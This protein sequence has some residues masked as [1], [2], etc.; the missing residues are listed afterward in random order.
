MATTTL[1]TEPR[2]APSVRSVFDRL[3]ARIRLYIWL[4]GLGVA[5]AWLGLAFWLSLGIDWL[6]EPSVAVRVLMLAAA[7]VVLLGILVRLIGRRAFVP[8][9]DS[10]MA[11]VLER[12]FGQFDDSLLTAVVLT[13]G[14]HDVSRLSP[15]MLWRTC[16]EAEQRIGG[17][18]LRDVFNPVPRNRSLAAAGL[19]A[20]GVVAFGFLAPEAM[21]VWADR[22]LT[23]SPELW[24]R[25]AHLTVEGFNKANNYTK[26][27]A[28]GSDL[29]VIAK[30]DLSA[31]LVPRT[32]E[33][34]YRNEG[35]SRDRATMHRLG[36]AQA[37]KDDFQRYSHTFQGILTSIDFDVKGGDY[38][39]RDLRIQAV[40]S[41]T[42]ADMDL[43]LTLPEY[44]GRPERELPVTGVMQ[45][46]EGTE[47]TVLARANK[48][49]T[50]VKVDVEGSSGSQEVIGADQLAADRMGF[51][52]TVPSLRD[53][54]VL[55]FTLS[56]T[57][58]IT[59]AEPV[60][61]S[62]VVVPD[63]PP[64]M[65]IRLGG[66]GSAITPNAR[67]P[68]VGKIT[69]DYGLARAWFEHAA[70]GEEPGTTA[71]GVPWGHPT[72]LPLDGLAALEVEPLGVEAGQKLLVSVKAADRYDLAEEPHVGTSERWLLDVVTPDQL[73]AMLEARELVLRQRFERIIQEAT[74][75][76]DLLVRIKLGEE[77]Q[78][79]EEEGDDAGAGAEPEDELGAEGA[80][81]DN[82]E[83]DNAEE[84]NAENDTAS[85]ELALSNRRVQRA[86]TNTRKSTHETMSVA[87]S[88]DDIRLQLINNRI[89]TEELNRRLNEGIAEPLRRIAGE[90][91]PELERRLERLEKDLAD[92][93]LGPKARDRARRQADEILIEMQKVLDRMLEL[94]DFNEALELL[95]AII[96]L[97]EELEEQT[98][99]RQ[100]Q[101]IRELLE[102][103]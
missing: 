90:M 14:R 55:S 23:L 39:V 17:V 93:Q 6:F 91:F 69:D 53:D 80:E 58:G 82:A 46:P 89:D 50:G 11:T 22:C 38:T 66:I 20:A 44:T 102:E 59:A 19:L 56:D 16:R 74:E 64:Q 18:R 88:F 67:L 5:L 32:A 28:R 21:G 85:R 36:E 83:E 27:V 26:K 103:D 3:R 57:D 62:L 81:E 96:K 72:D 9:T 61:L 54:T 40:E 7:A 51:E 35:G 97:Q 42:V 10:N 13:D 65:E 24:P 4:E 76:R 37:D 30:A 101:K 68:L 52:L 45:I 33:I 94:E 25:K 34:R 79:P 98:R 75:T 2:L 60:R 73:R 78:T 70:E 41:P 77:L 8:L 29:E 63:E 92:A 99:E 1:E 15:E 100:K 71:I 47:V 86:L 43:H 87:E 95:R 48:E 12:R 84:D 49:L 31:E